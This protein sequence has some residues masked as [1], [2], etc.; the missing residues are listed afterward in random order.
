MRIMKL[1]KPPSA[2]CIQ[3]YESLRNGTRLSYIRLNINSFVDTR[4]AEFSPYDDGEAAVWKSGSPLGSVVHIDMKAFGGWVNPDDGSVVV[5]EAAADH[6]IFSTIWTVMDM[7]HPVSGNRQFGYTAAEGG[8]F[9]FYSRGA[10]RTTGLLDLATMSIV[11]SSAH[12][13]WLSF[14]G[15]V[16][17]FV[18]SNGGSATIG[19]ATSIRTPWPDVQASS[20]HP[21]VG[22]I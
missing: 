4:I 20:H 10:D 17:A 8:G 1:S 9:V 16:A 2:T 15:G 22:W 14:Q 5:A 19:S 3:R 18:N 11:Y 12:N 6:W 13:L 21:S 7:A